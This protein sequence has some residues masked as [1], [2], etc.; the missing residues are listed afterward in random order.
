MPRELLPFLD[1]IAE[2]LADQYLKAE[3]EGNRRE[4]EPCRGV[5]SRESPDF[6][7]VG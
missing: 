6:R 2:M 7:I 3:I 5:E 4:T 1:A